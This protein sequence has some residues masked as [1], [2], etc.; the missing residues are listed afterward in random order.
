MDTKYIPTSKEEARITAFEKSEIALLTGFVRSTEFSAEITPVG[1]VPKGTF[2]RGAS[3]IDIFVVSEHYRE[4]FQNIQEH[5]PGGHVKRGELLIWNYRKDGFEIDLVFVSPSHPKIDTLQHT[6]FYKESLTPEMRNEV[7]KAKA[8]FLSS[9]V[10]AAEVG[11]I[12]G[13]AIEE[14]IRLHDSLDNVCKLFLQTPLED[15]WIQDPTTER[16][17]N[18]LASV[19]PLRWKQMRSVC[20]D[21]LHERV[22]RL[23]PFTSFAFRKRHEG[24]TLVECNR[25]FD[26]ATDFHTADSLCRKS[27]N[28]VRNIEKDVSF[29]C[30][31]FVDDKIVL[32]L[33]TTP[34]RLSP[35]KEVCI[36]V[37][38]TEAVDAFKKVHPY[39]KLYE[40][41]RGVCAMVPR[42]IVNAE[43]HMIK[44][45]ISRMNRRGYVCST[46]V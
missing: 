9:G 1:S 33:R 11:G 41:N 23:R 36:P 34:E 21:Y 26:R 17:R 16:S 31:T 46:I 22:V 37:E 42:T 30:D 27:G 43:S 18:L 14:L 19:T 29:F 28:E 38:L 40:K 35:R 25:Q 7:R 44:S 24:K 10:Y 20:H 39:A 13:V 15:L 4:L 12:T 32:A 3:D 8:L 6:E 5:I 45:F 2:L